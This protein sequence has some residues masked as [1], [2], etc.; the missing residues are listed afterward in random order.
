M[1]HERQAGLHARPDHVQN[2]RLLE[3]ISLADPAHPLGFRESRLKESID[4]FPSFRKYWTRD[5][6]KPAL[7]YH[8]DKGSAIGVQTVV[9]RR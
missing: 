5:F 2:D 1:T 8:D 3:S 7:R 9:R 6:D 4:L